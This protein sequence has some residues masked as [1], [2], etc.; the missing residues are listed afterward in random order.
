MKPLTQ[1]QAANCENAREPVCKCRCGGALHGAKRGGDNPSDEFFWALP[2][3]DPHYHPSPEKKAELAS[4]RRE[5]R[6]AKKREETRR[7]NA[8]VLQ[9]LMSSPVYRDPYA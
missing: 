7:K 4:Q 5:E 3:D 2:E 9:Y 8:L 1:K 6:N